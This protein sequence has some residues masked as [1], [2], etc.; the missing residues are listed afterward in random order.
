M[1]VVK[2]VSLSPFSPGLAVEIRREMG[3]SLWIRSH[4][5]EDIKGKRR[6]SYMIGETWLRREMI[7]FDGRGDK[8]LGIECVAA[9]LSGCP[10]WH[11]HQYGFCVFPRR[12]NPGL[13]P[14][15]RATLT[16]CLDWMARSGF[17]QSRTMSR[18]V[19][20]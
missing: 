14:T 19:T 6:L 7:A 16:G 15:G 20:S 8:P 12:D 1:D 2:Q 3:C 11:A 4:R 10:G 5:Q 9:K 13:C 18:V 17:H